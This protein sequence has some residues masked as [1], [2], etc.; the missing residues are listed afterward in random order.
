LIRWLRVSRSNGATGLAA[1]FSE[2]GADRARILPA[3]A[4]A[5][6]RRG[7]DSGAGFAAAF[8]A[9]A[10]FRGGGAG[11]RDGAAG[12]S[13]GGNARGDGFDGRAGGGTDFALNAGAGRAGDVFAG[14]AL[15]PAGISRAFEPSLRFCFFFFA[16]GATLFCA[17]AQFSY[18]TEKQ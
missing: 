15:R 8:D 14:A 16:K 4:S 7:S 2:T 9:S 6:A 11:F 3:T 1:S 13:C 17:K 10:D 12:A 18:Y 5:A